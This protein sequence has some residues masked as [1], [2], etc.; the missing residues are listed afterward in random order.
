MNC[1]KRILLSGTPVQNDL[2]EFYTLANFVNPG[3]LG[4]FCEYKSH[5]EQPIVRSYSASAEEEDVLLGQERAKELHERSKQFI[6][7]RTNYLINQYLPQK[8]E[9][10][11]FCKPT[12]EQNNLYTLITDYWFNREVI[13]GNVMPLTVITALKKIC[14]HPYLF[15]SD[16]S[17]ILDEVLPSIPTN[18]SAINTSFSYSS[19]FKIVQ[20]IFQSLKKTQEKVVLVSYFTQTLDL[21]EKVCHKEGLVFCR[22]DGSTPA[23]S[24]NKI[25]DKFNSKD[26][27]IC[28]KYFTFY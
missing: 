1:K 2:Q 22:L 28:R 23:A 16:K 15:T 25:V 27:S 19:K 12:P 14:N 9:L 20:A 26:N 17:T 8:H 24:R 11:V 21:L 3:I 10:V 13:V 18:L 7:R 5:Y 4:S 6:L